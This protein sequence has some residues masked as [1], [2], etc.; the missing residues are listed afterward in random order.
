MPGKGAP[1]ARSAARRR[2]LRAGLVALAAGWLFLALAL[3]AGAGLALAQPF[4]PHPLIPATTTNTPTA[5]DTPAAT[6]TTP[7]TDTPVPATPAPTDTSGPQPTRAVFS[8]PT[9]GATSGSGPAGFSPGNLASYG[10][11]IFTV[12]GCV[13]GVVGLIA[14]AFTGLTLNSDGWGPLI[15]AVLLGNR[16]G[17]RRFDHRPPRST[18]P[19]R[20]AP[21]MHAYDDWG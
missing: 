1:A 5:T 10:L 20:Q 11:V 6:A 8:E 13:L 18:R 7:A 17:K 9:L 19:D 14:L 12:L 15:K 4:A 21:L 16:R 3:T 2:M